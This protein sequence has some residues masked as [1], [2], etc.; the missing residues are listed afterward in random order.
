MPQVK[1]KRPSADKTRKAILKVARKLFAQNGFAGTSISDIAKPA[2]INQSLIY[3]HFGNKEGLWKQ[4]KAEMLAETFHVED[5]TKI[6]FARTNLTD[7]VTDF[8]SK[9][10]LFYLEHPEINRMILWQRLEG[11]QALI[12]TEEGVKTAIAKIYDILTKLY[13]KGEIRQDISPEFALNFLHTTSTNFLED[14]L[15]PIQPN[16]KAELNK[17][18]LQ[19]IIDCILRS[20]KP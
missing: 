13:A 15:F 10:Y 19:F 9:R 16:N 14:F 7:F 12:G 2:K 17:Q 8:V 11:K 5:A 4:V 20:L 18:Y 6:E 3:H 1:L